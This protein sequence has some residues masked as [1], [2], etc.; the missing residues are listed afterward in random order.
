MKEIEAGKISFDNYFT[1]EVVNNGL[2]LINTEGFVVGKLDSQGKFTRPLRPGAGR[3][4]KVRVLVIVPEL[5]LTRSV[6]GEK[7]FTVRQALEAAFSPA[8]KEKG[9]SSR[10]VQVER[11]TNCP[12]CQ[13]GIAKVVPSVRFETKQMCPERE[14]TGDYLVELGGLKE[15]KGKCWVCLV[16]GRE[17]SARLS[18]FPLEDGDVVVC[19]L[20]GA[21][22][23]ESYQAK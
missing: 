4:A 10:G 21:S 16:N 12:G 19:H 1:L 8:F 11:D 23:G 17:T 20:K 13:E 22:E 5:S 9:L 14:L 15:G 18:G 7:P 2:V 3:G 6:E